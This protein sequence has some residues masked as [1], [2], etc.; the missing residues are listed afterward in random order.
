MIKGIFF[1]AGGILY[2]RQ[3][4][5]AEFAANLL[6]QYQ[7]YGEISSRE[8]NDLEALRVQASQGQISH[9]TYWQQYL[10]AHGVIDPEQRVGLIQKI[11]NYSNSVQPVPGGRE[12]LAELKQR[13]F[14]LGIV[15]D[16]IY[17]LEWKLSRLVKAGVAEFIDVIACS[18]DL[19]VHKPDPAIY[20][21]A[22]RQADLTPAQ[23]AFVGHDP[24]ELDR[25]PSGRDADHRGQ[26]W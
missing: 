11:T 1:D 23:S 20:L 16:T 2:Q 9:D 24:K 7:F 8:E 22:L 21:D 19:G 15:T 6:Q 14:I 12:V 10:L 25:S 5:T 18:S 13:H 3:S 17:P 26:L 4:P